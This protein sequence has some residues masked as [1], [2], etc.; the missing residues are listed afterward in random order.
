[1]SQ[2][3]PI[4]QNSDVCQLFTCLP[5]KFVVDFA[6]GID[7][8]RERQRHMAQRTGFFARLYDGFTGQG[9]QH[10]AEINAS[11]TDGVEGALAWLVDL[12]DSVAKSNRAIHQVQ[13]RI[14][15]LKQ[16]VATLAHYSA[17]TRQMLERVAQHLDQRCEA[18]E[19]QVAR[20]DSLQR[21]HVQLDSAF[22]KW[23]AGRFGGL[24]YT[25]R[26]YA[27]LEEL[28]WGAFGE[29]CL[30][31]SGHEKQQMLEN[32][33]NRAIIQMS[34][35]ASVGQRERIAT[36][37]HWLAKPANTSWIDGEEAVRYL[38]D[39]TSP[40]FAPL[41]YAASQTPDELPLHVPKIGSAQRMTEGLIDEVFLEMTA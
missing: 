25:G 26:C 9:A 11:L 24:S 22:A 15:G 17:D 19:Q 34:H 18:L 14:N 13:Q 29:Y 3:E 20:I 4:G 27:V 38:G 31:A 35:D 1:M 10:Q 41:A 40:H 30:S 2:A 28:R 21:A 23:G 39:W 32:L 6:N 7:V 33:A 8:A 16:D 37:E 5:E 12:S 36:R